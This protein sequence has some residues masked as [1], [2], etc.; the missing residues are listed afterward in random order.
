MPTSDFDPEQLRGDRSWSMEHLGFVTDPHQI[1]V[2]ITRSR[3]GLIIVG[4][5]DARPVCITSLLFRDF[6]ERETFHLDWLQ[7]FFMH[8]KTL[9]AVHEELPSWSLETSILAS[10]FVKKECSQI[11]YVVKKRHC[12]I[13]VNP[14]LV[15]QLSIGFVLQWVYIHTDADWVYAMRHA[16][17]THKQLT[18]A[19]KADTQWILSFGGIKVSQ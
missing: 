11:P 16:I 18:L 2:G 17:Y 14:L 5:C 19:Q 8:F 10:G 13:A 1:C 7:A 12:T 3:F 9:A 15:S 4:E 6:M